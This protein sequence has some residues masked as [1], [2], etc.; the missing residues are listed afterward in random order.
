MPFLLT[1]DIVDRHLRDIVYMLNFIITTDINI[2][3]CY[4]LFINILLMKQY[5]RVYFAD[6][7]NR[8][9]K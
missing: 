2:V 3:H 7:E 6:R 9:Q 8:K 5:L 1:G 4:N